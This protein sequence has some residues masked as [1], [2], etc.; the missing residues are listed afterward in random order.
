MPQLQIISIFPPSPITTPFAC[1][2]RARVSIHVKEHRCL[3]KSRRRMCAHTHTHTNTHTGV[4]QCKDTPNVASWSSEC[5]PCNLD[6]T[7]KYWGLASLIIPQY[8]GADKSLV[9]PGSKQA[10]ATKL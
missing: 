7:T 6:T 4:F 10:T 8:Q 3:C 1:T 5:R 2:S 9:R